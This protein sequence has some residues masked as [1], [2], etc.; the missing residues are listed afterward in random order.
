MIADLFPL[1]VHLQTLGF[2]GETQDEVIWGYARVN[3]FTVLTCDADFEDLAALNG[4][5]PKVIHLEGMNYRTHVAAE[6]I[7]SN[8]VLISEFEKSNGAVL[9]LRLR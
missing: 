6:L 5:P 3:G 9:C 4:H 2:H 1:V 8:A 7:H